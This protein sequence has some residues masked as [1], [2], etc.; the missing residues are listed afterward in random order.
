M[1]K[2]LL[3]LRT[4]KGQMIVL[5]TAIYLITFFQTPF[6]Q[7]L[8]VLLLSVGST[9]AFHM[10][11]MRIN[12]RPLSFPSA[13]IVTGLIIGL[14]L[15]PT[16]PWYIVVFTAFMAMASKSF[17]RISARPIFNPAA[18]G[19]VITSLL[20]STT[21]AWWGTYQQFPF[22]NPL[23]LQ[24]L[25]FFILISPLYVSQIRLKRYYATIPFL[26]MYAGSLQ[27]MNTSVFTLHQ[28]LFDPTILFFSLIMLPEP[29]TSPAENQRQLLFGVAVAVLAIAISL[30]LIASPLSFLTKIPDPLLVS[31]LLVNL[32]FA[33]FR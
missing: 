22:N 5:L 15:D 2:I 23:S 26:L 30:L 12:K 9:V 16:I 31:L 18:F 24:L 28:A 29:M 33:K 25:L 13:A 1:H 3:T 21:V 10:L 32:L 27:L 7:T 8:P 4:P 14:L 17:L 20:F 6:Q 11:F 19:L